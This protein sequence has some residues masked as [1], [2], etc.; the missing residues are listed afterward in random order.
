LVKEINFNSLLLFYTK[1]VAAFTT[2][3]VGAFWFIQSQ[4]NELLLYLGYFLIWKEVGHL[5]TCFGIV[6]NYGV[7]ES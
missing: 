5:L 1:C 2:V 6:G 3:A 7:F 4:I